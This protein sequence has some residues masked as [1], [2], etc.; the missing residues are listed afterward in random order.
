MNRE[1]QAIYE[2][3]VLVE[4]TKAKFK[5]QIQRAGKDKNRLNN[6][7]ST[8]KDMSGMGLSKSEVSD[9]IGMIDS[10]I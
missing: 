9:L 4:F 1:I 8:I 7:K 3:T 2:K 6:L 5:Q 10:K